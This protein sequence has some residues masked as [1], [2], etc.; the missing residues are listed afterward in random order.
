MENKKRTRPSSSS[1]F[2]SWGADPLNI[3]YKGVGLIVY[4]GFW[5]PALDDVDAHE[6]LDCHLWTSF[7]G[8]SHVAKKD[9]NM[10]KHPKLA[11]KNVPNLHVTKATRSLKSQCYWRNGLLEAFLLVPHQQGLPVSPW[12]PPSAPW[13]R[14]CHPAPQPSWDWQ[15]R[16]KGLEGEW[17]AGL[18]RDIHGQT[19]ESAAEFHFRGRCGSEPGQ[20]TQ[21]GGHRFVLNKFI[22][23][24]KKFFK[25]I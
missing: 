18:T 5:A 4:L 12:L 16:P 19:A 1:S 14:V 11:G 25:F 3:F 10:P 13:G 24:K 9:V 17:P 23:R 22:T 15:A 6:E 20:P 21:V 8:D 2:W 7:E